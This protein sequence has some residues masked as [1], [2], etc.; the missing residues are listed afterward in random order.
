MIIRLYYSLFFV[1][2]FGR[3]WESH[4]HEKCKTLVQQQYSISNENMLNQWKDIVKSKP[5][6]EQIELNRK[7]AEEIV[8]ALQPKEEAS[9]DVKTP[10][11]ELE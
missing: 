10:A 3:K 5:L 9:T 11:H 4:L 2:C 8:I 6:S 1:S 7:E